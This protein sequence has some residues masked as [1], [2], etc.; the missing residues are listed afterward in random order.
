[1]C[2]LERLKQLPLLLVG[3]D[4][5]DKPMGCLERIFGQLRITI[6]HE[7]MPFAGAK[8]HFLFLG[9]TLDRE[10]LV[11]LLTLELRKPTHYIEEKP[12][13]WHYFWKS[14]CTNIPETPYHRKVGRKRIHQ[15][16]QERGLTENEERIVDQYLIA[17]QILMSREMS[18][19]R[20]EPIPVEYRRLKIPLE[21]RRIVVEAYTR[22]ILESGL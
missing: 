7:F 3:T 10:K 16:C 22:V 21:R 4:I 20:K 17:H 14:P 12:D 6:I 19:V 18:R 9:P 13:L 2:W 8:Y 11:Q 1:M 5:N 15:I